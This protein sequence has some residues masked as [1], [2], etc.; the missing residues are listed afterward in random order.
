M[1]PAISAPK[2]VATIIPSVPMSLCCSMQTVAPESGWIS[3]KRP[4]AQVLDVMR[5]VMHDA[6]SVRPSVVME[7]TTLVETV[8]L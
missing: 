7:H 8:V 1:H 4:G 6:L 2:K 5:L 3:Q